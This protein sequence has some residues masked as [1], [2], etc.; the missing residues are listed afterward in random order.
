MKRRK[1][2]PITSVVLRYLAQNSLLSPLNEYRLVASW[3]EVAGKR[4]AQ[5]Q[6]KVTGN[7]F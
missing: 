4:I 5:R 7:A 6:T 3:P 2:E 1:A